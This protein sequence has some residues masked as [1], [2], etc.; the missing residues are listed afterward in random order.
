MSDMLRI[1]Q[2]FEKDLH[3]YVKHAPF[4]SSHIDYEK[5]YVNRLWVEWQGY[6]LYLHKISNVA[7]VEDAFL[8][9]HPWPSAMRI[10][11]GSY[12]MDIGHSQ[13]LDEP[14]VDMRIHL[15]RGNTYCMEHPH[16]WHR[17]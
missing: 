2:T 4:A 3:Y 16:G 7:A 1:L 15:L 12:T 13:T 8:H 11:Q 14:S 6:R 9:P 10:V 17:V 5:P